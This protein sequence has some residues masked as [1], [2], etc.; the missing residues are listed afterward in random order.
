MKK[1]IEDNLKVF[2]GLPWWAIG[3][4][5][6]LVWLQFGQRRR[7]RTSRGNSKVVGDWA[8][9]LQCPWRIGGPQGLIV[10]SDDRFY[11][12]GNPDKVPKQWRWDTGP[13]RFDERVKSFFSAIPEGFGVVQ[14]VQGDRF[15]GAHLKLTNGLMIEIFPSD[16]LSSDDAEHWR[17]LQPSRK[18]RHFVV[19]NQ[20][21]K[22]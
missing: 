2:V 1:A 12:A 18:A 6:D 8:L 22:E 10:A 17:L 7:V 19:T 9:H 13:N 4:V 3:R 11:P 20:G 14:K 21:I 15:G 16:T 5:V